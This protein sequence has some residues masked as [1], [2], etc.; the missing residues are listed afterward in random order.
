MPAEQVPMRLGMVRLTDAAPIVLA[1]ARGMFAAEGLAAEIGVEPSWANIADKLAWGLLDGAVLLPPLAIG[2]VLGLRGPK[3]PLIVPAGISFNGNAITLATHLARPVLADGPQPPARAAARLRQAARGRSRLRLAVV[4]AFSTHDLLLRLFLEQGGID[5]ATEAEFAV[6]P[7][8]SMAAALAEGQVD[9]FCAGAPWGAVAARD[10]VGQTVA[11]TSGL[12]RNHPEKCLAVRA[13]W[14]EANP[15][16]LRALRALLRA[17]LRAGQACDQ[18]ACAP[19]LAD[20]LAR[21]EWVGVPAPLLAASLPGGAGSEVD[22][23]VFFAHGATVP[24]PAHA[25][26]FARQMARWRDMPEGAEDQA[27]VV[28][29]P[30]LH[31]EAVASLGLSPAPALPTLPIS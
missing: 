2:M 7:P 10:G 8:A 23:S 31:D 3:T 21:P 28:Y 30:G 18:P 25:H 27:A 11:V 26:W 12:W 1:H 9:G 16:A 19:A 20:L 24:H 17:L 22:R 13:S 6:V 29:R 5:P 4:H 14:A 15:A